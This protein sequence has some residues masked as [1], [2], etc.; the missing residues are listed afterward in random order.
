MT[1]F[2]TAA[3]AILSFWEQRVFSCDPTFT[4][5]QLRFY[6]Q[7]N[8]TGKTSP[9]SSD[10]ILRQLRQQNKVNYVVLNRPRSLYEARALPRV[11]DATG[12][13]G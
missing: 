5:D 12:F 8:Y 11:S 13:G 3:A 6:V 1:N 7:N 2:T 4:A 9:S 10:R